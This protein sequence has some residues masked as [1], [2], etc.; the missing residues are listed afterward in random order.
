[1]A[2]LEIQKLRVEDCESTVVRAYYDWGRGWDDSDAEPAWDAATAAQR[3]AIA[4]RGFGLYDGW[5]IPRDDEIAA[6]D[7]YVTI[8]INSFVVLYDVVRLLVRAERARPL[9]ARIPPEARLETA[10]DDQLAAAGELIAL[11]ATRVSYNL[12]FARARAAGRHSYSVPL[13]PDIV[14][15]VPGGPSTHGPGTRLHLFDAKFKLDRVDSMLSTETDEPEE[16]GE[17]RGTFKRGDLYKMHAYRDAIPNASSVWI[18][19]PGDDVRFFSVTGEAALDVRGL[20]A[21]L[22]GVGAIPLQ[23]DGGGSAEL[24]SVLER[25]LVP[26]RER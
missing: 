24:R 4:R 20:P 9:L 25:L 12:T 16:A 2:R 18:V 26:S 3:H 5:P 11:L 14:M 15:E 17:R 10:N 21:Q 8:G 1:M 23:P 19:Y 13:R 7:A 6:L 22:D